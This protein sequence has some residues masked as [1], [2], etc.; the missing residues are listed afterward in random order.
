[1]KTLLLAFSLLSGSAALA[2]EP[3]QNIVDDAWA[4]AQGYRFSGR[5]TAVRQAA[6]AGSGALNTVYRNTRMLFTSGEEGWVTWSVGKMSW[7]TR[8]D[9][10]GYWE[11]RSNQAI[12]LAPGWYPV[13]TKEKAPLAAGLLVHD[14][15]NQWG[16]I[17]DIDDTIL[18]SDVVNKTKLLRNS[19]TLTPEAREPVPGMAGLYKQWMQKNENPDLAP[20]FY[21]SASPRQLTE[22]I[23]RFLLHNS[24]PR[25][26]LQLKEVSPE[27]G[28][29][30][31]DQQ[32]YKVKRISAIFKAFPEVK[33]TLVGDDGERDPESFAELQALF[34]AQ[35]DSVWIRRVHPD[36]KRARYPGQQDPATLLQ[37]AK[38]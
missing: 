1:M 5:L 4:N 27:R 20:V 25:G 9:D 6:A 24:F 35:I 13:D 16:L 29:S 14:P 3:L 10:H 17:S 23:R 28:D 37:A 21:I 22:S 26:V 15:R 33:F 32:G 2:A 12:G 18:V 38:P 19:L 31:S 30:L 34:P 36:P 8:A 7:Q 11:L